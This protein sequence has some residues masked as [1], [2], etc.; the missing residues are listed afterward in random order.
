MCVKRHL[1]V[2]RQHT[3]LP[4]EIELPMEIVFLAH[5]SAHLASHLNRHFKLGGQIFHFYCN[6][7][8]LWHNRYSPFLN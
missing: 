6:D 4:M 1:A 3:Q 2:Q 8:P 5:F 7:T